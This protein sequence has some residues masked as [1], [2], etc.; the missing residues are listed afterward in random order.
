ML[1]GEL[2]SCAVF[3]ALFSSCTAA[4]C[5][6][7][8]ADES[9]G[10]AVMSTSVVAVFA[11]RIAPLMSAVL[12]ESIRAKAG[13][14]RT[15]DASA[16]YYPLISGHRLGIKLDLRQAQTWRSLSAC[17][18]SRTNSRFVTIQQPWRDD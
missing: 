16:A 4:A 13:L 17:L 2:L 12:L 1:W 5:G 6:R 18:W 7:G 8:D 15:C 3:L 10:P 14:G 9:C 11:A